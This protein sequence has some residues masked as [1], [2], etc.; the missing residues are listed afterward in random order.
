MKTSRSLDNMV[1]RR[2]LHLGIEQEEMDKIRETYFLVEDHIR[3]DSLN[4]IDTHLKG[5]KPEDDVFKTSYAM[6]GKEGRGA[7]LYI[8]LHGSYG[9]AMCPSYTHF[10]TKYLTLEFF[11]YLFKHAN[12]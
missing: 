6:V 9:F 4:I 12:I 10:F 7:P 1:A 8:G 11:S 3:N 5:S 2:T